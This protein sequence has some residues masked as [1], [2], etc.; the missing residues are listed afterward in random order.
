M[1]AVDKELVFGLNSV[2]IYSYGKQI[3]YDRNEEFLVNWPSKVKEV[4]SKTCGL[5]NDYKPFERSVDRVV[6]YLEVK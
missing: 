5:K 4:L 3:I 6:Y 1:W 2:L